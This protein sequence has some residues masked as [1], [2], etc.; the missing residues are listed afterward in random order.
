MS[1]TSR[2]RK[3]LLAASHALRPAMTIAPDGLTDAVIDH[4]RRCFSGTALLKLRVQTS[5]RAT[6][7]ALADRLVNRVPCELVR[8]VG[9]VLVLYK[10]TESVEDPG[11]V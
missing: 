1:L 4:L 11:A 8:R 10:P 5:D 2:E 6:C 3:A 9:R 7:D